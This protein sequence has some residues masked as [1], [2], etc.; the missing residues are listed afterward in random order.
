MLFNFD[1]FGYLDLV[2]YYFFDWDVSR[3]LSYDFNHSLDYGFMWHDPLFYSFEFYKFIYN[4]L[5]DSVHF[6]VHIL[7][8]NNFL[9]LG[10]YDWH[11]HNFLDFFNS[12][13]NH[14]LGHNSLYNL[15]NLYNFFDNPRHN[16]H[17]LN[18]LLNFNNFRYLHHLLNDLFNWHFDLFDA[19]DMSQYFN[20]LLLDIF[21]WFRDFDIVVDYFLYFDNLRLFDYERF[22]NLNNDRNLSLNNLNDWF[23]YYLLHLQNSLMNNRN[24][25]YPLNLFRN[26]LIDL[27]NFS[28]NFFNL[29]D[30]INR[31]YFLHYNLYCKWPINCVSN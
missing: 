12:L 13:L 11:L 25:N 19:V 3:Y 16:N 14:D 24:F 28:Y 7:F 31:H 22:S 8:N 20:Y 17:F 6:N 5:N 29:F 27:N 23:L 10:L 18:Y 26:F 1:D 15:W 30:S 2:V 21:Y 9:N 4:F